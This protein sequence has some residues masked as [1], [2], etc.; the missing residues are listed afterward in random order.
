MNAA[1]VRPVGFDGRFSKH[2]RF[3]VADYTELQLTKML[4]DPGLGRKLSHDFLRTRSGD[5]VAAVW[6]RKSSLYS[7]LMVYV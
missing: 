4:F 7:I 6:Y 2:S 5:A 3:E 1:S